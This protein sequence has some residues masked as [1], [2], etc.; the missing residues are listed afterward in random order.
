[1]DQYSMHDENTKESN[2]YTLKC[3]ITGLVKYLHAP[4]LYFL[5]QRVIQI[6]KDLTLSRIVIHAR[7]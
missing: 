7:T 5:L 6:L 1:M 3:L 2:T 4:V